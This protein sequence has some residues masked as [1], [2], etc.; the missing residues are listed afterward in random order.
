MARDA[1]NNTAEPRADGHHSD[2]LE[3]TEIVPASR[4]AAFL[5][6]KFA[7]TSRGV[8]LVEKEHKGPL[9]IQKPFYPEGVSV[10]HAYLLHPPGG[11]VSGDHLNI[12]VQVEPHAHALVTTPGAGRMY[13]A[14]ED[15]SPQEQSATLEI[16]EGGVVE[17]L[18]LEAI[19]FPGAHAKAT[20]RIFLAEQAKVIFW[21]VVCL[22]LPA[23][24]LTFDRGSFNQ[25]L[26]IY[27]N[28]R[29]VLQERLVLNDDSRELLQ[30]SIGFQ[31]HPIQGLM[32]AGPFFD[33]TNTLVDELRNLVGATTALVGVT[34]VSDFI[35]VRSLGD[36][37]EQVRESLVQLWSPIRKALLGRE[38]C[39]PRIWNT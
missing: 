35:V 7:N 24:G 36:C 16:A 6:L 12:H 39:P 31:Q 26:M 10:P 20:N 21:D 9:Y 4:W 25:N 33:D 3:T 2:I 32:V 13:R 17:W 29:L 14:R 19:L 27:R 11:L 18:P 22:G 38:G 28:N 23:N 8:R 37:S 34:R 1:G 15:E 5:R 30:A